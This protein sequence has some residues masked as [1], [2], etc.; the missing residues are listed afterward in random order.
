MKLT[1]PTKKNAK[2]NWFVFHKNVS[3]EFYASAQL[4]TKKIIQK[5]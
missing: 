4:F 2:K 5:V 3:L 1:A